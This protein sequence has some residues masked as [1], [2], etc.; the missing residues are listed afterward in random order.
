MSSKEEQ[1]IL[2]SSKEQ[3]GRDLFDEAVRYWGAE[4]AEALRADIDRAAAWLA[5]I[6][7]Y[8]VGIDADE[9]DFL[10]APALDEGGH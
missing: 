7:Q 6:S 3:V 1:M 9:P 10:V 5:L 2:S 8:E 4:R